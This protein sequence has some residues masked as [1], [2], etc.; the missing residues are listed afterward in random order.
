MLSI[1]L[2]HFSPSG[3][4]SNP[5]FCPQT[6]PPKQTLFPICELDKAVFPLRPRSVW[7]RG[8]LMDDASCHWPDVLQIHMREE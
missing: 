4:V 1:S 5:H 3:S 6:P 8:V 2:A 7:A